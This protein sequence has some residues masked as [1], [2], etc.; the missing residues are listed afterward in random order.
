ML[1]ENAE[2][3]VQAFSVDLRK[4]RLEVLG[5][6]IGPIVRR[7]AQIAEQLD[8]W[9]ADEKVQ[10]ADWQ[11]SWS[12]TVVKHPRGVALVISCVFDNFL[13]PS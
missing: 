10:M 13:V 7:A 8:E 9:A 5:G 3:V 2:A 1:R 6:E 11:Q 4:P 12:S